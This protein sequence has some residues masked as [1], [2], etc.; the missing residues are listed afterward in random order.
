MVEPLAVAIHAVEQ[1]GMKK[2]DTALVLG[3][4]AHLEEA[5]VWMAR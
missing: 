2:G 3:E 5:L 4:A 1:S